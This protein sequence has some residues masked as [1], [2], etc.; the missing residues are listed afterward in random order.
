MSDRRR[1]CRRRDT[2]AAWTVK[3]E[4]PAVVGVPDSVPATGSSV[5][6]AGSA[7]LADRVDRCGI[8]RGRE[9]V[10]RVRKPDGRRRRRG[11]GGEDGR[12]GDHDGDRWG[13]SRRRDA[14]VGLDGESR[15]ARGGRRPRQRS[16]DRIESE[17]GR[18]RPARD[19]VGRCGNSRGC[20]R[21]G[22]VRNPDG[23]RRRRGVG[24]E[25][26][27]RRFRRRSGRSGI[28]ER[29]RQEAD[30]IGRGMSA[31]PVSG[32]SRIAG[33]ERGVVE[34]RR[35]P[36]RRLRCAV[37]PDPGLEKLGHSIG[38]D[39]ETNPVVRVGA[40]SEGHRLNGR[41]GV[42]EAP[43]DLQLLVGRVHVGLVPLAVACPLHQQSG[44]LMAH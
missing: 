11:V 15:G 31:K 4:V 9:R 20:E 39:V 18:Q 26:R 38:L 19:R 44:N 6:P 3:V 1:H 23:R 2:V 27:R 42:A 14:V 32:A 8:T 34:I 21:I 5:S 41:R 16:R 43:N 37:G 30:L 29:P 25:G 12:R 22:G 40:G 10:G 33:H 36:V 35:L 13:D 17:S 7:P 28:G 24:G